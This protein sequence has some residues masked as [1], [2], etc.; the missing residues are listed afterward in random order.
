M[1]NNNFINTKKTLH[2]SPLLVFHFSPLK[3]AESL[4]LLVFF[5]DKRVKKKIGIFNFVRLQVRANV[6]CTFEPVC[7]IEQRH[8]FR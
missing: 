8:R 7:V 2:I 4:P 6:L 1:T 5:T 3:F